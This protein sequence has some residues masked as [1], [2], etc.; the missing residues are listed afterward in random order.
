MTKKLE[1]KEEYYK[2]QLE[3]LTQ[4]Y[5]ASEQEKQ[6]SFFEM[7]EMLNNLQT[8]EHKHQL[9]NKE[10]DLAHIEEKSGLLKK[11][12]QLTRELNKLQ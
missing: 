5:N 10:K 4:K 12:D 7:N 3:A 9:T 8:I 1:Y 11:I 2:D 6:K